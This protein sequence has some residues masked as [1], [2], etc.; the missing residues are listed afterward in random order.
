MESFKNN[1]RVMLLFASSTRQKLLG[2]FPVEDNDS[3]G[4]YHFNK[5]LF[6]LNGFKFAQIVEV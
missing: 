1:G 5:A 6:D 2:P 4:V 3:E